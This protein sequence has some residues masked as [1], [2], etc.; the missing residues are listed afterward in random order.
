MIRQAVA[1]CPNAK[2]PGR[3]G[4]AFVQERMVPCSVVTVAMAVT[5]LAAATPIIPALL[6]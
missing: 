2:R 6:A 3:R 4:G 1:A 5:M